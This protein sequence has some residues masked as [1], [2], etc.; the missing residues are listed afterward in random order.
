MLNES[1]TYPNTLIKKIARPNLKWISDSYSTPKNTY[2]KKI[3]IKH[4][5]MFI[6]EV[7]PIFFKCFRKINNVINVEP[8][9]YYSKKKDWITESL[10]SS[11]LYIL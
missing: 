9:S 4:F 8:F 6:G 1:I 7:L 5:G 11:R 10:R 2:T 3:K